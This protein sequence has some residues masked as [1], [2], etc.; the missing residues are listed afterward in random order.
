MI[1]IYRDQLA[2]FTFLELDK[3]RDLQGI[4]NFTPE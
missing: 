1:L 2:V 4:T 3:L